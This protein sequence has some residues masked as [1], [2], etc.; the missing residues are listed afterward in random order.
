MSR[1]KRST[2]QGHFRP[3]GFRFLV[4]LLIWFFRNRP[5]YPLYQLPFTQTSKC[6]FMSVS[7]LE[8]LH[9]VILLYERDLY[10]CITDS[11][12]HT[13]CTFFLHIHMYIYIYIHTHIYM[14]V[15]V[16]VCTGF[17]IQMTVISILIS[18]QTSDFIR[19]V[20][21]IYMTALTSLIA[22]RQLNITHDAIR[23]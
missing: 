23:N 14:C 7:R 10:A 11:L 8:N 17:A 15:C 13:L 19:S 12:D 1:W 9:C 20:A 6:Y 16:C 2:K 4:S 22:L 21:E 18:V 5:I 3:Q